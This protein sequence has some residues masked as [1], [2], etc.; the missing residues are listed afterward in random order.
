MTYQ[1]TGKEK[2]NKVN[3]QDIFNQ[4]FLVMMF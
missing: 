3:Q 1:N 2:Q 4:M